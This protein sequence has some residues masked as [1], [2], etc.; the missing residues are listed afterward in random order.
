MYLRISLLPLVLIAF[1]LGH[2]E[3]TSTIP[4]DEC[5]FSKEIPE[6]EDYMR[7]I[8]FSDSY[9][10]NMD[11]KVTVIEYFDPN[12]PHCKTLHP[13]MKDVI[14]ANSKSARFFMIPFVLWQYSLPQA[15]A[16]FVAGQDGKYFEMLDAQYANQQ[17]GGMSIDELVI[18]AQNIGLDPVQF[19]TRLDKGLNQPMI[20]ARR[21]E[22]SDLGVRGTPALMIN[23]KFVDGGSKSL[24]CINELIK[25]EVASLKQG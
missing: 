23:G 6:V 3:K 22:I 25:K 11:S 14:A 15:E 2:P 12:C 13:I 1:L 7:L 5:S 18:L 10:G 16:L 8:T 4:V 24:T 20:L 19:R 17:A 21:Q 9:Q